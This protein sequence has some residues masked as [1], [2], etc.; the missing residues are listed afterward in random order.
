MQSQMHG[1]FMYSTPSSITNSYKYRLSLWCKDP[2]LGHPTGWW[3][4]PL[5]VS[6]RHSPLPVRQAEMQLQ[7]IICPAWSSM[8]LRSLSMWSFNVFQQSAPLQHVAEKI[9]CGDI[10]PH[11]VFVRRLRQALL[12][13]KMKCSTFHAECFHQSIQILRKNEKAAL[14]N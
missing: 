4:T 3:P 5:G 8:P 7:N 10:T 6:P 12:D 13:C 1:I 9:G 14:L 2:S 11:P